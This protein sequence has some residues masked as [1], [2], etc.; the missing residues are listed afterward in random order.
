[1]PRASFWQIATIIGKLKAA[2]VYEETAIIISADH[3]ENQGELGIYGEHGTADAGT[4]HIPMVIKWPGGAVSVDEGF[5]YNVD[6]APTC[7]EL[8]GSKSSI[9]ELWDGQ[10]YAPTVR[11]GETGQGSGRD[12][13]I[14]SQ[15]CHVCQRG[16]RFDKW[17]Y[18][19]T[20][21]DGLLHP[22]R[23]QGNSHCGG[24][25]E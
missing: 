7:M 17:M 10:S 1:M 13:L 8:L 2:G 15:C 25:D 14:V 11:T 5:H 19:R 23:R 16:L 20:Y 18:I 21:C 12:E 4:C 24:R 3:G 6:W 9:P 22:P